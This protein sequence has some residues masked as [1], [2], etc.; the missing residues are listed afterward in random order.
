MRLLSD[1]RRYG[2]LPMP[3][4]YFLLSFLAAVSG[5]LSVLDMMIPKPLPMMK[6]GLANIVTLIMILEGL[7]VPAV[8]VALL[9][10]VV[11]AVMAGT[12]F[13]FTFLLSLAGAA[14]AVLMTGLFFFLIRKSLSE[15]GLSV[16]GAFFNTVFQGAVVVLFF[17]LD[18]GILLLLSV[19]CLMGTV[20]GVLI[21]ILTRRIRSSARRTV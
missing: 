16:I 14:G 21:G 6:I 3:E 20:S 8:A 15:I 11:A 18:R 2:R 5:I 13:S 12:L 19:F 7:F 4:K 9:R 1:I 17:G 10:S